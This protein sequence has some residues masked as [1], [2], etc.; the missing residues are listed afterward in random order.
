M[1][2]NL[3]SLSFICTEFA[4]LIWNYDALEILILVQLRRIV[5][6]SE[7]TALITCIMHSDSVILSCVVWTSLRLSSYYNSFKRFHDE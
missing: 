2:V 7:V 4:S 6:S 3:N 1:Y 5:Q